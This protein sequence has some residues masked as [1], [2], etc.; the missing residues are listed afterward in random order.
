M[1]QKFTNNASST[2]A[3]PIGTTTTTIT[4][5]TGEG[6]RFPNVSGATDFAMVTLE[7]ATANYEICRMTDRSG[8]V[9]TVVRAQENTLARAFAAGDRI[10]CRLTAGVEP[11]K[12]SGLSLFL[13]RGEVDFRKPGDPTPIEVDGVDVWHTSAPNDQ[14]FWALRYENYLPYSSAPSL[15]WKIPQDFGPGADPEIQ[16]IIE[17]P[18]P[19]GNIGDISMIRFGTDFIPDYDGVPYNVENIAVFPGVV[20]LNQLKTNNVLSFIN[21]LYDDTNTGGYNWLR[22]N[23]AP[24][25]LGVSYVFHC[26]EAE[27]GAIEKVF[28]ERGRI[29]YQNRMTAR[30]GDAGESLVMQAGF[31][32]FEQNVFWT[33]FSPFLQTGTD[34]NGD[35]DGSETRPYEYVFQTRDGQN[36]GDPPQLVGVLRETILRRDGRISLDV[37]AAERTESNDLITKGDLDAAVSAFE[38]GTPSNVNAIF[39]RTTLWSGSQST[40]QHPLTGGKFS[41]YGQIYISW[42]R[43]SGGQG[44]PDGWGSTIIDGAQL[45]SNSSAKWVLETVNIGGSYKTITFRAIDDSN[46]ELEIT[47]STTA[48]PNLTYTLRTVVGYFK[49]TES[50]AT[51]GEGTGG[52]GDDTLLVVPDGTTSRPPGDATP[53]GGGG[54]PNNS[55]RYTLPH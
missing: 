12:D 35:P 27:G 8:D 55:G 14:K 34:E 24:G 3:D 44:A 54:G 5:Q 36:E 47:D 49:I 16:Y 50:V 23:P 33:V 46:F 42:S 41:E 18:D 17:T 53:A 20:R 7:D 45:T 31:S 11:E 26:T 4:V 15:V 52:T 25:E 30:H 22:F 9:L 32:P 1:T 13:Q 28:F 29:E 51:S 48:I 6:D 19:R 38:A 43:L 37:A 40:G 2:L 21:I 39:G 10:E